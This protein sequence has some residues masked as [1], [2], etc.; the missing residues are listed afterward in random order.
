MEILFD[1]NTNPKANVFWVV[2]FTFT[3]SRKSP[4]E[5][6]IIIVNNNFTT[7]KLGTHKFWLGYKF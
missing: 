7:H 4:I 5:R 1:R 2:D 3:S 6:G